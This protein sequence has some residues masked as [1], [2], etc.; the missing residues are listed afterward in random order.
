MTKHS[1]TSKKSSTGKNTVTPETPKT[2]AL[3]VI[4]LLFLH[5][6]LLQFRQ[7]PG[8]DGKM[9]DFLYDLLIMFEVYIDSVDTPDELLEKFNYSPLEEEEDNDTDEPEQDNPG[10]DEPKKNCKP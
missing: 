4:H 9:S 8:M 2:M 3:N 6:L 7:S 5:G 10:T 1:N